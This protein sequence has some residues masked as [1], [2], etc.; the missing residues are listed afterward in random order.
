MS[1]HI[2][3]SILTDLMMPHYFFF[4]FGANLVDV[5]WVWIF[6]L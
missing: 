5:E 4:L 1:V 2:A 6:N 3:N